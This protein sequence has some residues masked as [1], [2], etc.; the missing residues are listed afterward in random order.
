MRRF[1]RLPFVCFAFMKSFPSEIFRK[2]VRQHLSLA[3][4]CPLV[5]YS[6]DDLKYL[7]FYNQKNGLEDYNFYTIFL[8]RYQT[9]RNVYQH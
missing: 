2:S 8:L 6:R 1:T 4:P 7:I 5:G 9:L 3:L